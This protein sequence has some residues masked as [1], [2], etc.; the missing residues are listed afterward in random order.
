MK[1]LQD[2]KIAHAEIV[3][4]DSMLEQ[5]VHRTIINITFEDGTSLGLDLD[6]VIKTG[7]I[8]VQAMVIA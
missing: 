7:G 6:E 8:K 5:L 1:I 3:Y 4:N 2:K